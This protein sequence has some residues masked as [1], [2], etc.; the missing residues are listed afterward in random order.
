MLFIPIALFETELTLKAATCQGKHGMKMYIQ[1]LTDFKFFLLKF[2]G[3]LYCIISWSFNM[4][5][6]HRHW[7]CFVVI[8]LRILLCHDKIYWCDF[9]WHT[10]HIWV[11]YYSCI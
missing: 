5:Q 10:S 8:A 9:C 1:Q 7:V 11:L 2:N 4:I 3:I 6:P